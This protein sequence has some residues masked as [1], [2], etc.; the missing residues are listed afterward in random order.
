M[1]FKSFFKLP[2]LGIISA[3]VFVM[4]YQKGEIGTDSF[5]IDNQVNNKATE[6]SEFTTMVIK[7]TASD[8]QNCY[9]V[10]LIRQEDKSVVFSKTPIACDTNCAKGSVFATTQKTPVNGKIHLDDN[11]VYW[12]IPLT[13]E[14]P[15]QEIM[16]G[17]FQ[18]FCEGVAIGPGDPN[19]DNGGTNCIWQPGSGYSCVTY[20][21]SDCDLQWCQDGL[22]VSAF[23]TGVVVMADTIILN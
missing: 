2:L 5:F 3:L 12:F 14:T 23:E 16:G 21:C 20:C 10:T 7:M 15:P 17:Y 4:C 8:G 18:C 1:K 19:C 6:R 22:V 9:E 13:G 11:H